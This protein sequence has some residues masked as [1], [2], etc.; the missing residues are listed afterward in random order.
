MHGRAAAIA[1]LAL[2]SACVQVSHGRSEPQTLSWGEL[3]AAVGNQQVTLVLTNGVRIQGTVERVLE[4]ALAVNVRKTSNP[5]LYAAGQTSIA[6][7]EIAQLRIKRVKGPGRAIGAA[8]IG[9][10]G[11][12]ATLPWALSEKRVNV[13]DSS[14][15]AS[16]SAIS[17]GCV[18]G[19]YL[20]GRM[21]D[22]KET[23]FTIAPE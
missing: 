19:G 22:S 10:L 23:V 20:V 5:R 17:A 14:R 18:V 7:K 6:R 2:V 12:L 3:G 15:I 4:D 9:A 16:W 1:L 8:G 13:S 11:A 21:I